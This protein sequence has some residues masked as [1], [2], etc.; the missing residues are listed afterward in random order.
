[1]AFLPAL[2]IG[3]QVAGSVAGG[4]MENSAAKREGRQLDEAARLD[5]RQGSDDA[6]AAYRASRMQLGEDMAALAGSGFAIGGGSAQDLLS[7]ALVER[8]L[9][10]MNIRESARLAA[11]DKRR[12]AQARRKAGKAAMF[13]GLLGGVAAAVGGATQ[14]R[15]DSRAAGRAASIR[16]G[17]R[18][19]YGQG[20]VDPRRYGKTAKPGQMY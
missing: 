16:S 12:Q 5:E 20:L 8:E 9:E 14:M 4:L 10:G 19:S 1:M 6:M 13:G 18:K 17:V 15:S 2:A 3:L 7:A 11:E